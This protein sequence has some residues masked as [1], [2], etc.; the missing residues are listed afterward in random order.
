MCAYIHIRHL[1]VYTRKCVYMYIYIC[2][3][4]YVYIQS[5]ANTHR[6]WRGLSTMRSSPKY[7]YLQTNKSPVH[8][9]IRM[10]AHIQSR[11]NPHQL[12]GGWLRCELA[13]SLGHSLKTSVIFEIRLYCPDIFGSRC[14]C[15]YM[16]MYAHAGTY[17]YVYI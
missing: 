12:L 6:L 10:Y 2:I 11:A 13:P 17:W 1:H 8:I 7:I 15:I 14:M 5:E 9:H 16:R 3:C 4:G